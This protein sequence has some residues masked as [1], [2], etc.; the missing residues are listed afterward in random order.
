MNKVAAKKMQSRKG[1][2]EL[3]LDAAYEMLIESGVDSVKVMPL[4][5]ALNMSR[6]SFYWHFED[7]DALLDTLIRRWEQKNTGNLIAQTQAYAET[8]T[9]AVFNVFDCWVRPDLFDAR[10]DCAI[11]HWALQSSKLKAILEQVDQQRIDAIR[12]MFARF[13]YG[14][15]QAVIRAHTVYYTQVGYISMMVDEPVAKR[16]QRMPAYVE[17]FSGVYPTQSEIARFMA[18]HLSP[19]S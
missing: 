13:D 6:T 18:R 3:W 1:S 10:L 5:K 7:R 8:I 9:E 15:E 2:E 14:E 12:S 19:G 16:L 17:N 4:A 11:R